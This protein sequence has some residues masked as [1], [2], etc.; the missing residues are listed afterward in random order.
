MP[1]APDVPQGRALPGASWEQD[2]DAHTAEDSLLQPPDPP[3]VQKEPSVS[4]APHGYV[5]TYFLPAGTHSNS[6]G[7]CFHS[8][9]DTWN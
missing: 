8:L 7:G 3:A 2:R 9:A 1:C 4:S 6:P 5:L